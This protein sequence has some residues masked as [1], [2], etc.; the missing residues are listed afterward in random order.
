MYNNLIKHQILESLNSVRLQNN[1]YTDTYFSTDL[2]YSNFSIHKSFLWNLNK[3]NL[4][5]VNLEKE[6]FLM[7]RPASVGDEICFTNKGIAAL[8]DSKFLNENNKLIFTNLKDY[9]LLFCNISVAIA[10]II[11]LNRNS[12]NNKNEFKNLEMR[13]DSVSKNIKRDTLVIL[14]KT[15][16]TPS[17]KKKH[18][19]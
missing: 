7:R 14:V 2:V 8:T 4:V 9:G 17:D 19:N 11:A 3:F 12:V 6:G 1:G 13:I 15:P 5:V 10:A 16:F 18:S